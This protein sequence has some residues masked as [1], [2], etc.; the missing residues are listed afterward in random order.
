MRKVNDYQ[1]AVWLILSIAALAS[2]CQYK[3][4]TQANYA[5]IYQDSVMM[6]QSPTQWGDISFK[7]HWSPYFNYPD[8]ISRVWVTAYDTIVIVDDTE[9]F[10]RWLNKAI[11]QLE[12][13]RGMI[14]ISPTDFIIRDSNTNLVYKAWDRY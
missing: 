2:S 7:R 6:S 11:F 3:Q 1:W 4:Q 13:S 14:F 9:F 8:S 5:Q 12:E 10:G